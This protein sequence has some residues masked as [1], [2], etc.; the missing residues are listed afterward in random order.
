MPDNLVFYANSNYKDLVDR[1]GEKRQ[2]LRVMQMDE[3]DGART[4]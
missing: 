1:E 2:G 3:D 4:I